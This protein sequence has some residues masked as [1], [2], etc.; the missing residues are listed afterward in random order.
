MHWI[1]LESNPDVLNQYT[2][3]LKVNSQLLFQ[4]V[5]GLDAEVLSF[6]PK[7]IAA[8]VL[9]FPITKAYEEYRKSLNE[10]IQK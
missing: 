8:F 1:P 6:I 3:K 10:K 4:D 5:W 9:L 2:S 7:P